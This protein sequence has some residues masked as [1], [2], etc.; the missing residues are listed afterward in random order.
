MREI[1][2]RG[3]L[4][5][6]KW[7]YGNLDIGYNGVCIITPD[8]T[9][10][11]CYGQVDPE[12]VGQYT[13]VLDKN[14]NRI[15]EGDIVDHHVQGDILVCRGI[16]N[17]DEK[18]VGYAQQLKTMNQALCL[19]KSDAWEIIGNIHDNPELVKEEPK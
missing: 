1:L 17:F 13:G 16:I 8:R 11:G 19:F 4:A 6:G 18:N 5:T 9:L 3:K 2:F 7:A 15:F 10:L 14:G 12:T